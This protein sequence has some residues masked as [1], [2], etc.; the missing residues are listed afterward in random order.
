M[1]MLLRQTRF[2][3]EKHVADTRLD[4][5]SQIGRAYLSADVFLTF[6]RRAI[7]GSG[8]LVDAYEDCEGEKNGYLDSGYLVSGYK[9]L[10]YMKFISKCKNL[11]HM[12]LLHMLEVL[13]FENY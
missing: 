8:L 11:Q 13:L 10:G 4:R 9:E 7:A 12:L 2:R 3:L 1:A 5:T 6:C